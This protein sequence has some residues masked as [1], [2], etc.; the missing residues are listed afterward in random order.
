MKINLVRNLLNIV[1]KQFLKFIYIGFQSTIINYLIYLIMYRI[2]SELLVSASLGYLGG[3]F[4]SYI[5][6][7][8]WVFKSLIPSNFISIL[9]FIMVYFIGGLVMNVIVSIVSSAGLDYRLAW[10]VG[11]TYAVFNNFL[12]SKYIVFRN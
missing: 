11:I 6:G 9:K 10:L 12:G 5:F 2:S 1:D 4:N 3:I 7:K 8:K